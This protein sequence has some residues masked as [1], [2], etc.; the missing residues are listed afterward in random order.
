VS[1]G[2]IA[3]SKSDRVDAA[4]L[5]LAL[6]EAREL[7]RGAPAVAV[8]AKTGDGL[9]E[10]R[11]AL[12]AAA[13][14]VGRRTR[15]AAAATRLFID[16]AFTL[17]GVGTVATGT[18][19]S[20]AIR[21][22]DELTV[23]PGGREV[24]VRTV[25]VH[26]RPVSVAEAGQRVAVSLPG[27]EPA[28][29]KRGLA[30]VEAGAFR[31]S[32]RLDIVLYE[33]EPVPDALRV[34]VHHGTAEIPAR[35]VRAGE[36]FAQLRLASRVVAA[37]GDRVVLRAQTTLGGGQV[38]DPAPP[39]HSDAARFE[40][41]ER[42]DIAALVHAP[43][44][45]SDVRHLADGEP[46]GLVRTGAW[47][48]SRA[49]LDELRTDVKQRLAR[50]APL[51]PGIEPPPEP[52][53]RAVVPLLG[54]ERRGTKLYLPGA[55]ASPGDR[56]DDAAQLVSA[57]SA[58]GAAGH[59]IHD[60]ELAAHLERAGRIVRLG[61]GFAVGAKAYEEARRALLEEVEREGAITLGRFR[62]LL[63]ISR[64]PAQLLLER[65]DADGTTRRVGDERVLRRAARPRG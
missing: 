7:V 37:R 20:G 16:R 49:W 26:D 51:D 35:V 24:R 45:L 14:R 21:S 57:V 10:L 38:L 54:L 60:R 56:A 32:Y 25:Q 41:L 31:T 15:P 3:V 11:F 18:L 4:T 30:L 55:T 50:A 63:G 52:W 17:R 19:W 8:S 34:T 46:E 22:G 1:N 39:R 40:L 6:A 62:D 53:A 59:K 44:P 58:A 29:L 27:V 2:V 33:L 36:R 47:V 13:E 12:A 9:E 42:R 23:E 5:E 61:D 64:R 65:F 48:F 43:V 28:R